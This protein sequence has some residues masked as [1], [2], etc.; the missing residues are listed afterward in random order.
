MTITG[1]TIWSGGAMS[2]S[3]STVA[4]A[5][6]TLSGSGNKDLDERTLVNQ[7][8]AVWTGGNFR[9][10][11][12]FVFDNSGSFDIQTDADITLNLFPYDGWLVNTGTLT[13]TALTGITTIGPAVTNSGTVTAAAGTIQ[14]TG[15]YTQTAGL[16]RLDGGDIQSSA[17]LEI[18]GGVLDGTGTLL[19]T[20][21]STGG[22]VARAFPPARSRSQAD[23]A[24]GPAAPTRSRSAG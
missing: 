13:K 1:G 4:A 6:L 21:N 23:T 15:A 20:V 18:Q 2:G 7:A 22:Q 8:A 17:P 11:N 24:R 5:G 12:G 3:G 19:A 14:F 9:N 16:T 10:G